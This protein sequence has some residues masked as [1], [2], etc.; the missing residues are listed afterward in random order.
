VNEI[1]ARRYQTF[2]GRR[3]QILVEGPSKKN[4]ERFTGR[5]R[6]NRIVVFE[7]SERHRGQLLEL[8]IVRSGAFTLYGDPA[9]L[10]LA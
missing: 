7:G 3:V 9:I 10:N 8:D 6:C 5:T 2:V 1:A 4:P